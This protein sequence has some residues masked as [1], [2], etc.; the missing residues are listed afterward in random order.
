MAK[1][2]SRFALGLST[3][4]PGISFAEEDYQ[5][6]DDIGALCVYP[7][8]RVELLLS[9]SEEKSCMTDGCGNIS[10]WAMQQL[11]YKFTWNDF[12]SA[13]QV[14]FGGNKVSNEHNM[15]PVQLNI[16]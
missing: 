13:I 6:I 14:R 16:L 1:W 11:N 2:A 10:K 4:V 5:E 9:E 8:A 3:S 7:C 15:Q 12:P